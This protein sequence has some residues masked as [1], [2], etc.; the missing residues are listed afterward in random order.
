MEV[1]ERREAKTVCKT[2]KRAYIM[3]FIAVCDEKKQP[4]GIHEELRGGKYGQTRR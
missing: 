2:E 3:L 1:F 4:S